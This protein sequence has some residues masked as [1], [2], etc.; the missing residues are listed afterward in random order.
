MIRELRKPRGWVTVNK[1]DKRTR[2]PPEVEV[3]VMI[4]TPYK[5]W[6]GNP[7]WYCPK[8]IR[9]SPTRMRNLCI[10][11]GRRGSFFPVSRVVRWRYADEL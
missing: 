6:L 2:I 5:D 10:P 11:Q 7:F 3:I 9:I 4:R 8:A 1:D